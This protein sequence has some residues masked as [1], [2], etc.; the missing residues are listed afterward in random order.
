MFDD[1]LQVKKIKRTCP[2]VLMNMTQKGPACKL[3]G[4]ICIYGEK[5]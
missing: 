4:G 3:P 1:L 5:D 2:C